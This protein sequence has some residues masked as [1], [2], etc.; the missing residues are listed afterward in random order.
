MKLNDFLIERPLTKKEK[1]NKA[2]RVRFKSKSL[3]I[4]GINGPIILVIKEIT[5]NVIN[6]NKTILKFLFII[7]PRV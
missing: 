1:G 6:T 5:K 4:S 3:I 7:I 2:T